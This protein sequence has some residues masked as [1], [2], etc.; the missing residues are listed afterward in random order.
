MTCIFS[1]GGICS[2]GGERAARTLPL[3]VFLCIALLNAISI[4]KALGQ[5]ND[6]DGTNIFKLDIEQLMNIDV[7][8]ATG[9]GQ[10][11][12][13]TPAAMYVI[14]GEDIR[15]TGHRT[16][17]DALRLAP[18]VFVG[19]SNAHAWTVGIRGFSGGLANKT[20]I[21]IDGRTVYDPLF[22]GTFWDVQDLL[23]EDVERIEVIRGP[24]ATLWGA[25][26]VNGV[27]NVIS[28]SARDT[29]G[30][31]IKGGVGTE[32]QGFGAIRYGGQISEDAHY[33]VWGKYFNRDTFKTSTGASAHDDWDL[34]HGGFRF[35]STGEADTFF[36]I[37]SEVYNL[38]RLGE[39][40]V[41]AVP[42]AHLTFAPI[43]GDGWANG[44]H[45]LARFGKEKNQFN[46][47]GW[48]LQTYYDRTN[49]EQSGNFRVERD[50]A[51]LDFRHAFDLGDA[52]EIMWGLAYR[53][54]TD[55]TVANPV[56]MYVPAS[57]SL[58]TYSA[59]IQ[60][61]ITLAPDR[62]F[63]MIGSKFE[64]NSF[65]EFEIQP[66]AR[67]WWTPDNRNT[68]WGAISKPVRVPS[69]TEQDGTLVLSFVDTG[70]A[71]GGPPSGIIVPVAVLPNPAAKSEELLAYELG[72][73]RKINKD[74]MFAVEAFY[75][76]YSR[77]LFVPPGLV[78][79]WTNAGWGETYGA[80]FTVSW[81]VAPNWRMESS[82]SVV[83]VQIHGAINNQDEGNAPHHQVK[84]HSYFDITENLELNTAAYYV[85]ERPT[86]A[87]GDYLRLDV[88]ITWRI[89]PNFD[90]AI[91][92]QNLL[93]PAHREASTIEVQRAFFL[94]GTLR[95]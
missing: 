62:W 73:R 71:A 49:R 57:R 93:D 66:S 92:G 53:Y 23:L 54:S 94:Q 11:W 83:D 65:T 5:S 70:L 95:Y 68:W 7:T 42:G 25:N 34:G 38:G 82:Y 10:Q 26:A 55:R 36:T 9:T 43:I 91:W 21:L 45:V 59:F 24:G 75:N 30:L 88:G 78:G 63:A 6:R 19:Q 64:H 56:I 76:D 89:N 3:H 48:T 28:K 27:V 81:Q 1:A 37:Q 47:S 15:R 17:A 72:Y 77:L 29:Q 35:D 87:A 74:L 2:D 79:M 40:P 52:H 44:G 8:T 18:G 32:E 13:T 50:T 80:E 51:D 67:L 39:M 4:S 90:V 33:R 60:D 58:N 20:L 85:D 41:L 31:V 86:N 69:R 22:S 12:F 61:T 16:L 14:T 46:N 84:F